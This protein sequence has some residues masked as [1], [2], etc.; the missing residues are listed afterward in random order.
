[1]RSIIKRHVW[2]RKVKKRKSELA[3]VLC[4]IANGGV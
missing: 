2:E 1:M 4:E 3:G